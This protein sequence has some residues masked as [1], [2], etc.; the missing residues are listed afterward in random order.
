MSEKTIK[1][2]PTKEFF[3]DM[4][5]RDIRLDRSIIDLVD[6]CIDG[7][8]NLKHNE[9]YEGLQVDIF[10]SKDEFSIK[11]NCGGFSLEV[12]KEYAFRFGRPK[13]ADFVKHSIGRFGVGMKRSLLKMGKNFSVESKNGN[14]HFLVE[15]DVDEW[16]KK[17]DDWNFSYLEKSDIPIEKSNL[18]GEDGTVIYVKN[19][20]DNIKE[21]FVDNEFQSKLSR[22][23]S[24]AL[25]YSLLKKIKIIL[26]KTE[27][28]RIDIGLLE[29][30]GLKPLFIKKEF[31]DIT[32]RIFAGIGEYL[33]QRAGWY[34]F[35]NDRL[36][37]EADKSYTTGWKESKDDEGNVVKYHND[38]AM[39]RGAIFFDSPNSSHLPMTTTKTGID[40]NHSVFR[41][42][43]P[44]I[45]QALKQVVSFLKK[46]EDKEEG[47]TLINNS[48]KINIANIRKNEKTYTSNFTF[49]STKE[50]LK[51]N[52]NVGI[53]YSKERELV[54]K[55]K[56]HFGVSA[57]WEVGSKTFD[58]FITMNKDEL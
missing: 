24:M 42:T 31:E 57:N 12:A 11:D 41:A 51:N 55:V 29:S 22:E 19:L 44:L 9:N 45:L 56:E 54:E 30:D 15:V 18:N 50:Q 36:V 21:E 53:S 13:G 26:N 48:K 20:Y 6:N 34:I 28:S 35:C 58:Y 1:A 27:I 37:L 2:S 23:I 43:R 10:L 14:D 33:P 7:A 25:S 40:S 8:K 17:P 47:E 32:V 52:K 46:V 4:L 49:P 39:F 38:Y 16:L 3:I 5:T